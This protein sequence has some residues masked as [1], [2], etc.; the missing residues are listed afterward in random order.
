MFCENCGAKVEKDANFCEECGKPIKKNEMPKMELPKIDKTRATKII[1]LVCIVIIFVWLIFAICNKFT[2]SSVALKYFKAVS[3]N[4]AGELYKYLNVEDKDFTSKKVF[5]QIMKNEEKQNITNYAVTSTNVDKSS[6]EATVTI[7]YIVDGVKSNY[8]KIKLVKDKKNKFL[9]FSN[10]KVV[11]ETDLV[12][13][14]QIKVMKGS[15][16][17]LAGIVLDKKY[18]DNSDNNIDTYVI[19]KM[20]TYEYPAEVKYPNGISVSKT[21]KPS[22]YSKKTTLSF[23]LNDITKKDTDKIKAKTLESLNYIYDSA[24]NNKDFS[25]IKSKFSS[26]NSDV[27]STYS[28]FKDSLIKRNENLKDIQFKSVTINKVSVTN[29]GY[30]KVTFKAKYKTNTNQFVYSSITYDKEYKIVDFN[31]F[32]TYF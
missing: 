6:L 32:K 20:F 30:L 3:N 8:E 18:L 15:V 28:T 2:P 19:P 9:I 23:S 10:W 22:T 31:S 13:N 16:V 11:N 25:S 7:K 1:A 27:E 26:N 14:Y 29:D 21:I 24:L 4:D 17:T 12:E 5:K